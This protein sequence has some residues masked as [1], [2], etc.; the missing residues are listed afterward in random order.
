MNSKNKIASFFNAL[1]INFSHLKFIQKVEKIVTKMNPGEKILFYLTSSLVIITGLMLLIQ[2]HRSFLIEIPSFGGSFT[3]GLVGSP[4]FINPL[5]AISDTDRDLTSLIYSGLLKTSN[6]NGF[7]L[8]LAKSYEIN[9]AGTIYNFLIKE[10][11]YFHDGKEVT[12]DDVIFTIEKALDEV[13]KSPKKLNWEGVL[14]EKINNKEIRFTL[15]KPYTPFLE[16]LTLGILPKHIWENVT[17]EEFPFSQ[18]NIDPIGS[19]PYQI[20][21]IIRNSGGIPTSIELLSFKKYSLGQPKIKSI[22]FKFF[23]NEKN[24]LKAYEE[25]SIESIGSLNQTTA[26]NM[27]EENKIYKSTLPRVFG[28]FF[29][30]NIASV[31]LNKEI[32]EALEVA[33]PKNKIV[34]EVLLGYGKVIN[35]P[36]PKNV[37][38]DKMVAEGD[39][40]KAK[41][42][43]SKND[44]KENKDGLLE[45][46]TKSGTVLFKFSIST[47]DAE[48]L[49]K[50]ALILK[51]A[52]EK[53]GAQI[54]IK[55]F[56]ASD[57]SQNIIRGRKYDALLFGEVVNS[58]GN[59]YPFWHSSERIDPGLNISLYANI[60]ADKM[61][62]EIQRET[63]EE[64]RASKRKILLS[65]IKKDKPAIFLFSPSFLYL[66]AKDI[67]N[68]SLKE[69][70]TQ[71]ERFISI[72]DWF[73]ETDKVWKFFK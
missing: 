60:T 26:K 18:F 53:L 7:T 38:E 31:F 39:I 56:E 21:K 19:G 57:L 4:R 29:N 17:P 73:I 10:N 6:E 40:E 64:I 37:E 36:T 72:E 14:V 28:L 50:T 66:P 67:K 34:A 51:E 59:L 45:K 47:S 48:E 11:V 8:D 32:R 42:I 54:D 49:K 25:K 43:L 30:Q 52:W 27:T 5:L 13:I 16:A 63:N 41:A 24:L 58:E 62:E 55:I 15:A 1:F 22:I 69:T 23:Q 70:A 20:Q 12:A 3:E 68:I 33:T 61:L 71:S 9:E 2:V 46:K 44:W 65:E 35:G